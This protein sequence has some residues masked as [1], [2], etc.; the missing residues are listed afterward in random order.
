MIRIKI[1]LA[2]IRAH[3]EHDEKDFRKYCE[4]IRDDLY[5]RNEWELA[6]YIDSFLNPATH[7]WR[8]M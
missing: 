2:L 4:L 6:D 5:L 3:Y 7:D 1:V 8:A